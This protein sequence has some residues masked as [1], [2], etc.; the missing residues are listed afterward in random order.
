[1]KIKNKEKE[2]KKMRNIKGIKPVSKLFNV[3]EQTS[4]SLFS[5]SA[6]PKQ[7]RGID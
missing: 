1:V 7:T 2:F 5:A 4:T 6:F 3:I